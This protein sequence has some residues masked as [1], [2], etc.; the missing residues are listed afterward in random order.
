M[1]HY[2]TSTTYGKKWKLQI[3]DGRT[4]VTGSAH[5]DSIFTFTNRTGDIFQNEADTYVNY[6]IGEGVCSGN[7]DTTGQ[8]NIL[9][10]HAIA[11]TQSDI[12][13]FNTIVGHDAGYNLTG[14]D[15]NTGYGFKTMN[16]ITEVITQRLVLTRDICSPL[17]KIIYVLV[18]Q[19]GP[20]DITAG[21]DNN[22]IYIDAKKLSR[23]K[24]IIYGDQSG[25]NQNLTFNANV[26][27]ADDATN[28]NGNL[29]VDGD[30][31]VRWRIIKT[32]KRV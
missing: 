11:E 13:R 20:D 19:S 9:F 24:F 26:K 28:S 32:T 17:P 23:T 16:K 4:T 15:G 22:Q 7:G 29:I 25:S 12:G 5:R 6:V 14:G 27:I 10:G 31:I 1:D 30:I 8:Y 3:E 2:E 18:I 21:T